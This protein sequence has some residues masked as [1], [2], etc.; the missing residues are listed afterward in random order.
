MALVPLHL[1]AAY[2][3]PK[4]LES[5]LEENILNFLD[6]SQLPNDQQAKL[7]SQLIMRYQKTVREPAPP[8]PVTIADKSM[9]IPHEELRSEQNTNYY[10]I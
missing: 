3:R 2:R 6:E 7:L 8:I 1:L 5:D 9:P 4:V 10:E